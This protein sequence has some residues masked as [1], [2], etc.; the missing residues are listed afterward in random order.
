METIKYLYQRKLITP[1]KWLVNAV[2]YETIM[3]SV[4]YGVSNDTSD[5][6]VYG[7]CIP[8]KDILFP[9][10]S[11]ELYGFDMSPRKFE[12]YQEHHIDDIDAM[13][14]NGRQ[15]DI[16][17]YNI[18]KYVKLCMDN[19]PNMI[20]SLFTPSNCVLSITKI[21][22]MIKDKRKMFLHKGAWHT[23]RGYSYSQIHKMKTK[24]KSVILNKIIEFEKNH[25]I[26]HNTTLDNIKDELNTR[27]LV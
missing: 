15:Y 13:G 22:Q 6:D 23:F 27:K 7:F 10:L 9:H 25:N 19:N 8:P 20:D 1:P 14:G 2:H 24:Q 21:G 4:A 11:G 12:Q 5:M 18:V 3:G 16:T 17:I 26:N